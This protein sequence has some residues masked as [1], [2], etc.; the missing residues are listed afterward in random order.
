MGFFG[1]LGKV[2]AGKPIYGDGNAPASP[3][4]PQAQKGKVIPVVRVS[5]VESPIKGNRLEVNMDIRNESNMPMLLDK[6]R[7]FGMTRE[8]DAEL[9]A[10]AVR[11]YPIY[12]GPVL[13]DDH[14][15]DAELQYRTPQGD[16][17]VARHEVR[18]YKQNDGL[19]IDELRLQ[20]PIKDV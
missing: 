5:R 12:E 14:Y 6:I 2:L 3:A 16:Y 11:E 18:Y 13:T 8:L 19:H 10:G 9:P 17:F 20:L 15:R 7:I 4:E 1:A